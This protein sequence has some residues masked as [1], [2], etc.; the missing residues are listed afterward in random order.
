MIKEGDIITVTSSWTL[1]G[2]MEGNDFEVI[3][4]HSPDFI[5]VSNGAFFSSLNKDDGDDWI[6]RETA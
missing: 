5:S 2:I 4:V 3:A 1:D 6:V